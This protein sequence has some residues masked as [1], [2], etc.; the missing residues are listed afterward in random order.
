VKGKARF[1]L[2]GLIDRI[3]DLGLQLSLVASKETPET[4]G[5]SN[6]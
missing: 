1:E 3:A 5:R 2:R 4:T 6:A